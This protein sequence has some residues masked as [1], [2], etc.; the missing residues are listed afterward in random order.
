MPH[1]YLRVLV[2]QVCM[3]AYSSSSLVL[4]GVEWSLWMVTDGAGCLL[5]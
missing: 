4:A 1:Q 2:Q 5:Q 3:L